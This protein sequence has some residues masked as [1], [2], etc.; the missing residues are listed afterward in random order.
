VSR[1]VQVIIAL[2][3]MLAA[4]GVGYYA[5]REFDRM[6][7]VTQ[8]VTPDE[9]IPAG[10]LIEADMLTRRDAARSFTDEDIFVEVDELVGRVAAV[11]LRPG[12]VIYRTFAAPQREYRLVDD[13]R[14]AV[15]SFPVDPARAVGG[16]LQPGHRLDIWRLVSVRPSAEAALAELAAGQWATATLLVE[17]APVVDVRASSGLAVARSPQAIPGELEG[18]GRQTAGLGASGALQILTVGVPPSMAQTILTLVAEERAGAELWVSLAPLDELEIGMAERSSA[19]AQVITA[20]PTPTM[21]PTARSEP[22][23]P[24]PAATVTSVLPSTGVPGTVTAPGTPRSPTPT[25][26]STWGVVTGTNGEGLR[27]RSVPAGEVIGVLPDGAP[28]EI[29][30]GVTFAQGTAWCLV[31]TSDMRGWVSV[32]YLE[33]EQ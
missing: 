22:A 12:M 25:I 14:L 6:I 16:Q 29:L 21:T 13:P 31:E 17:S 3:A 4:V 28:V 27:V 8:V 7:T 26:R 11:P 24:T 15:V 32:D 2:I 33:M 30:K 9:A 23:S 10:A 20:T 5:Y 18:D 19:R 1:R